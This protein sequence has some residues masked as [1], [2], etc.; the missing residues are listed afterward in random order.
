MCLR[1]GWFFFLLRD[2]FQREGWLSFEGFLLEGTRERDVLASADK[3]G[4]GG[5]NLR[6]GVSPCGCLMCMLRE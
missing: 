2:I 1:G 5:E 3:G 6:F 4:G